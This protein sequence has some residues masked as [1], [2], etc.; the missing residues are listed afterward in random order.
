MSYV[1][2]AIL[3]ALIGAVVMGLAWAATTEHQRRLATERR[4]AELEKQMANV[5]RAKN[6]LYRESLENVGFAASQAAL[7]INAMRDELAVIE[8]IL[9]RRDK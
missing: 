4:L 3:S 1:G 9:E 6:R 2:L 5:A 7:R 8:R